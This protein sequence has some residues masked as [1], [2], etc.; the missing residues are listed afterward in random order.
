MSQ[1]GTA[2][3]LVAGELTAGVAGRGRDLR[4]QGEGQNEIPKWRL[5]QDRHRF[6]PSQSQSHLEG[7]MSTY[8]YN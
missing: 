2:A 8:R 7:L 5:R 4:H 1:H 6:L 3:K